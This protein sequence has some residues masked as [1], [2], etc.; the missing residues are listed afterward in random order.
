M[1][2]RLIIGLV[3]GLAAGCSPHGPLPTRD[4]AVM[5]VAF[6]HSPVWIRWSNQ[7]GVGPSVAYYN[8]TDRDVCVDIEGWNPGVRIPARTV[9]RRTPAAFSDT[10]NPVLIDDPAEVA[11]CVNMCRLDA[12]MDCRPV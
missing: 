10:R 1:R 12:G 5:E 3:L 7:R 11:R 9:M 6:P 2:H 4:S 8:P